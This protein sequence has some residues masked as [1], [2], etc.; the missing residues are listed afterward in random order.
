MNHKIRVFIR[1]N[2]FFAV[3]LIL[4][5]VLAVAG[6]VWATSIGNNVS[7]SGTLGATGATTLSSTLTASGLIT[8]SGGI[9]MGA[10][11]LSGTTG[12]IDYTNFDVDASG[13]TTVG[14]TLGVTG[15]TTFTGT[16]AVGASGTALT[17]VKA[18]YVSCGPNV[19]NQ[20]IAATTT[21]TLMCSGFTNISQNDAVFMTATSTIT[22]NSGLQV[23]YA[24]KASTTAANQVQVDVTNLTGAA[25]TVTTS[26]WRY[27]IIR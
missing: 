10:Q 23:I 18:G 13:N 20:S 4:G 26:T 12:I 11:A 1:T 2:S 6:S 15:A 27:L 9:S 21:G 7:V 16:A 25:W 8:A 19:V 22:A 3:A 14:G 5:V 17:Q 24:G